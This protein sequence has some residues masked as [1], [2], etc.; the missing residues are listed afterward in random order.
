M[1]NGSITSKTIGQSV[2]LGEYLGIVGSSGSSSGPHLHFEVWSGS[3][4]ATRVDPYSGPCNT[5]NATSWWTNQKPHKESS[6][7]KASVHTTDIVFPACPATETLNE[8]NLFHIPFSGPGLP[9]G[10][11]KFYIFLRDE[12]N[13]LTGTMSILR[14]DASTYLIW[15]YN[16]VS[17]SNVRAFG[18]S[19]VLP[20]ESGT[21]TFSATYNGVT[22]SSTFDIDNPTG[23]SY[24]DATSPI[25]VYPNPSDGTITININDNNNYVI[26][27][28]VEIY[29]V[30]GKI[31]YESAIPVSK[32]EITLNVTK[33]IYFY[34]VKDNTQNLSSGKIIIL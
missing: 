32:T 33:G 19:K 26:G 23:I 11:A 31:V 27:R 5:L 1:K 17:N 30:L 12:I 9:P 28:V 10:Y 2:L 7:L 15:T 14:P 24:Q 6:L 25:I 4:V 22:C 18:W 3:T 16:S 29:N 8:S 20:T 21:Y 13:G 34:K